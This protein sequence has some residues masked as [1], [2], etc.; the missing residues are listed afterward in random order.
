M[1]VLVL[2]I[3]AF[4]R[5]YVSMVMQTKLV[6][7]VVDHILKTN[8]CPRS[9]ASRGNMLVLRTSNFQG[10]SIRPIVSRH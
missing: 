6:V 10:A 5:L 2:F 9:E 7:V 3:K 1:L 8:I 4:A